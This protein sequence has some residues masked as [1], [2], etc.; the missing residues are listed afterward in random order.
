MEPANIQQIANCA[1]PKVAQSV[2]AGGEQSPTTCS[3]TF[4]ESMLREIKRAILSDGWFSHL[5]LPRFL[6][7]DGR[8]IKQ[9]RGSATGFLHL[10]VR[11]DAP[12]RPMI[13]YGERRIPGTSYDR[14][15]L[16]VLHLFPNG[17]E[18]S[19]DPNLTSGIGNECRN[20]AAAVGAD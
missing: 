20:R 12:K 13:R 15:L 10:T 19:P 8:N 11:H 4:R 6:F 3:V 17:R 9:N 14:A 2:D 16:R 5:E 18:K 7:S 1:R